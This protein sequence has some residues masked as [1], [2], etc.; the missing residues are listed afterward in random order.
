MLQAAQVLSEQ[1]D[2]ILSQWE[3]RVKEKIPESNYSDSMVLRDH[4]PAM[5][6]DV[7]RILATTNERDAEK[8]K[9]YKKIEANSYD[10]G[11]HRATF[12]NYTVDRLVHEYIVFHR[13]LSDALREHQLFSPEA[14]EVL[15][16]VMETAI[17]QSASSFGLSLRKI[18]AEVVA[19]L[20]HDVR[21]PLSVV[22]TALEM[23]DFAAGEEYFERMRSM[24]LNNLNKAND[25]AQK[26][27][28]SLTVES[29]EGMYFDFKRCDLV[30]EVGK[31]VDEGNM[32]YDQEII[33]N[34]GQETYM[35][36]AD[37]TSIRRVLENLVTNAIRFGN[38]DE[39]IEVGLVDQGEVLE[40][41]VTNHGNPIP[42]ER[43]QFIL[44]SYRKGAPTAKLAGGL[45]LVFAVARA[46]KGEVSVHSNSEDGTTFRVRLSKQLPSESNGVE[47]YREVVNAIN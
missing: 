13:V 40:L 36:V 28:D 46:H 7:A 5:V 41:S 37:A 43:Q 24:A 15:K 12:P 42:K 45:P 38:R 39:P 27:M 2:Q 29:G 32:I 33:F 6:E 22:Q 3:K 44:D 11:R 47:V 16:Y 21:N 30:S 35:V 19:K 23:M 14:A 34:P 18:Q 17:L 25:L 31:V 10:H 20:A 8:D 1:K 9:I 26:L 4:L